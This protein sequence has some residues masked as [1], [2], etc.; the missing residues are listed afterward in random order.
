MKARFFALMASVV[1]LSLAILLLLA[2]AGTTSA[3]EEGLKVRRN[4]CSL[5]SA[6]RQEYAEAVKLLKST[7]R[8]GTDLSIYDQYV[9][10]HRD[11]FS[12][13]LTGGIVMQS[14]MAAAI[15]PWHREFLLSF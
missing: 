11:V 15:L 10:W 14:H 2:T 12:A 6:E 1:G 4:A 13:T 5:N 8:A 3:Q 9:K 7:K